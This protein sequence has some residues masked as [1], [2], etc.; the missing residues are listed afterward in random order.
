MYPPSFEE[1]VT[2]DWEL[3]PADGVVSFALVGL[4]GFTREWVIPA[5]VESDHA[6]V[7]CV[8]TGDE[9]KGAEVADDADA[10]S[11]LTYDE[12]TAGV[13]NDRYDAVYI[14]TP[15][16]THLE[17]TRAA[18]DHG[19]HVLCEKPMETSAERSRRMVDHCADAGVTLMIA[20]RVHFEPAVRWVRSLLG[21]E[22]LGEPVHVR[23]SMSQ[24]LFEMI[25]PDPDQWRLNAELSGGAALIDLGVYPLNTTRYL[26]DADPVTVTGQLSSPTDAFSDVDEH[27]A[28][29]VEF[30]D[31]VLGAYTASQNAAKASHLHVT[32]T[33]GSVRIEPAFFG[34]TN[35]TID[36]GT[37]T[38]TIRFEEA[39]AIREEFEYFVSCVLSDRP[40]EPDGEHGVVDIAAIEAI[41]EESGTQLR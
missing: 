29:T 25:S 28:F 6:E 15:N 5:I 22:A 18:A 21:T 23:G 33:T 36:D 35:V 34:E 37:R 24:D 11:V 3:K 12:F 20:Y 30:D 7:T 13:D 19:A 27:A 9:S 39:N 32:T 8:V 41:R 31:G 40:V 4:G 2:E 26:I 14:A 38:T 17:F 1:Y 16:A 10:R